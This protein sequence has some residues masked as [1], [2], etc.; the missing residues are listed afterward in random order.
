[1]E[2]VVQVAQASGSRRVGRIIDP[3]ARIGDNVRVGGVGRLYVG[4][5]AT[6]EDN[7]LLN[8]GAASE[9][10]I[11]IGCRSKLKYGAVLQTYDGHV[12]IGNRTSIGEYSIL[13]GHGGLDIGNYVIIGGHCYLAGSNHR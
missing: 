7:V 4:P 8:L 12:K 9:S 3:T 1:M 2:A 11:H 13:A 6:V 10:F 5:Y